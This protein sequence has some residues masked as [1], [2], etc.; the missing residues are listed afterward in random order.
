M[1]GLLLV[2]DG[3]LTRRGRHSLH[4]LI[5]GLLLLCKV[6]EPRR[7]HRCRGLKEADLI[8]RALPMALAGVLILACSEQPAAAPGSQ[9]S[10]A[11][12]ST[13]IQC[14]SPPV[15]KL[16]GPA[17]SADVGPLHFVGI[18]KGHGGQVEAYYS[19]G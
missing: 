4:L 13:A 12:Q 7:G 14:D 11:P 6:P 16:F 1:M 19:D 17:A 18:Y 5:A 3:T 9:R 8:K 2:D 15:V 10:S